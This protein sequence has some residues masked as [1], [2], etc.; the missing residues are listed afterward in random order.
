MVVA[1]GQDLRLLGGS[2][3]DAKKGEHGY[4]EGQGSELWKIIVTS[5][6]H[7]PLPLNNRTTKV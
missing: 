4:L 1:P 6:I 3:D 7:S 2:D 5:R